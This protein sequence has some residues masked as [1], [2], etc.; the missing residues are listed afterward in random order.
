MVEDASGFEIDDSGRIHV[1]MMGVQRG[2]FCLQVITTDS[3]S[4]V[5]P[6][7]APGEHHVRAELHE[8]TREETT[9]LSW[10][11]EATFTVGNAGGHVVELHDGDVV[12]GVNFGN[13]PIARPS[14]MIWDGAAP[15][16]TEGDGSDW[17]D[18][19][20]W[21]LNG[22]PDTHPGANALGDDVVFAPG[23]S[24]IVDLGHNQDRIVHSLHFMDDYA[25]V[26]DG[27]S[28]DVT[29]GDVVV[30]SGVSASINAFVHSSSGEFRKNGRGALTLLGGA[31]VVTVIDGVLG[32]SSYI[33]Q[34][35]VGGMGTVAPGA[36][37]GTMEVGSAI[38]DSGATLEI[39][40][41][42]SS[43]DRLVAES[44]VFLAGQ[45]AVELMDDFVMPAR[46][47]SQMLSIV[48]ASLIDGHFVEP[49]HEQRH[50][51]D[52]LFYDVVY[53]P[54]SVELSLR[55]AVPGDANG[56]GRV[57]GI[58]LT[59]WSDN[60]FGEGNW[61]HGDFTR[62]GLVD[63][64]DF[65]LWTQF[66]FTGTELALV[67]NV[68]L[69]GSLPRAALNEQAAIVLD[70]TAAV[71]VSPRELVASVVTRQPLD[72]VASEPTSIH[73][74]ANALGDRAFRKTRRLPDR[75]VLASLDDASANENWDVLV[76]DVFARLGAR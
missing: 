44:A 5:V 32:G 19:R 28:L 42:N 59:I 38:F 37:A 49:T 41:G 13:Q 66:R 14:E 45:L 46:G 21:S 60:R 22:E 1:E 26:G 12:A 31:D 34:L 50:L 36:S 64:S 63:G 17:D 35:S 69:P 20:N 30:D 6:G 3:T 68:S 33:H 24:G 39:E 9:R 25:L 61:T 11:V 51:G 18:E 10:V 40:I 8:R 56:D 2:E 73:A 65:D 62:D 16:G 71:V 74:T 27:V 23:H 76:D 7:L 29:S 52:G 58:D 57:D 53:Q 72:S 4:I 75:S 67:A 70:S 15:V 47:T 55:S 48:E 54:A 43:H